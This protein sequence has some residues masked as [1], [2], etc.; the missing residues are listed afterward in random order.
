MERVAPQRKIPPSRDRDQT[1]EAAHRVEKPIKRQLR[2]EICGGIAAGKTTLARLLK[3][4]GLRASLENFR[5]NPFYAA[6]YSDPVQYA[7]ETE[8]TFLL[9][10]YHSIKN[11]LRTGKVFVCD[12]SLLTDLAYADLNLKDSQ[13]L[14]FQ[15]LYDQVLGEVG[16]PRLLIYLHCG[17]RAELT[18]IKA[19]GRAE[20]QPLRI[21]YLS[22]LNNAIG[23]VVSQTSKLVK[24]LTID[25]EHQNFASSRFVRRDVASTVLD[26]LNSE[27]SGGV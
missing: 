9:Q 26:A 14:A 6:F 2:V 22:A 20:E 27:G 21:H 4:T 12:F 17:A 15:N 3:A 23:R 7:F 16:L 24:V 25:S 5:E 8:T 1:L 19:R 11:V 10:H 18:R 13:R